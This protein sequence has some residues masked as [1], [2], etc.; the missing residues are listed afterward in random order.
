MLYR[1]QSGPVNIWLTVGTAL[2]TLILGFLG[3]RLI[4]PQATL[5]FSP[6]RCTCGRRPER[7]ISSRWNTLVLFRATPRVWPPAAER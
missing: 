4:A 3:G 2:V 7:S 5:C 6:P 1:R